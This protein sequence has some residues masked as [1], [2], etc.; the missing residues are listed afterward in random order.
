MFK[1]MSW[2]REPVLAGSLLVL[3]ALFGCRDQHFYYGLNTSTPFEKA[4]VSAIQQSGPQV[5]RFVSE[6]REL[7]REKQ[8]AE[9]F[10]AI[11]DRF[12]YAEDPPGTELVQ[13]AERMFSESSP[14]G[15]CEDKAIMI[16]SALNELGLATRLCLMD[17][18]RGGHVF[19]EVRLSADYSASISIAREIRNLMRVDQ[20]DL[21]VDRSGTW[22]ILDNPELVD[23]QERKVTTEIYP[24]GRI[25]GVKRSSKAW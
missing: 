24:D 5:K 10:L 2:S 7:P 8:V 15:D 18:A 14:S 17:T 13:S 23:V 12:I 11:R 25:I 1:Q 22:L 21:D 9:V 6:Y 3:L 20:L 4:C 19:S 16:S